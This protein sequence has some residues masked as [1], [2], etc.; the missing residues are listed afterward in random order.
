MPSDT[1]ELFSKFAFKAS[2]SI[3]S[4]TNKYDTTTKLKYFDPITNSA[5]NNNITDNTTIQPFVDV[6]SES[7]FRE[8]WSE[9]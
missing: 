1:N 3:N 2:T 4:T 9:R 8:R 5:T 7:G 6:S